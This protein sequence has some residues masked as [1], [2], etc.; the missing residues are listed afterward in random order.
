MRVASELTGFDQARVD[1][2]VEGIRDTLLG[3]F[4]RA[5]AE[6]ISTHRAAMQIAEERLERSRHAADTRG[7]LHE[8]GPPAIAAA[9][10]VRSRA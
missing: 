2:Q 5:D 7:L 3:I 10:P 1:G 4:A 6:G 8:H 9:A